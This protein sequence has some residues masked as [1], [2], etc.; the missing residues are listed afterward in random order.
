MENILKKHASSIKWGGMVVIPILMMV[1]WIGIGSLL[2]Q[3]SPPGAYSA[4]SPE[5]VLPTIGTSVTAGGVFF[6]LMAFLQKTIDRYEAEKKE[7]V[8]LWSK[9][10]DSASSKSDNT[11]NTAY[12]DRDVWA[13]KYHEMVDGMVNDTKSLRLSQLKASNPRRRS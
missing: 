6:M 8:A 13:A 3:D 11:V 1:F 5:A 10:M 4:S 2:G 12:R 9:L 7:I